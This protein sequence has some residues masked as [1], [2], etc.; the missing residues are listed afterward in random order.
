MTTS[1]PPD[2]P[3]GRRERMLA[4][5]RENGAATVSDLA[6]LFGVSPMTV[7]RDL[8]VIA[9]DGL[10]ERFRGGARVTGIAMLPDDQSERDVTLRRRENVTV[11]TLLGRYTAKLIGPGEIVALDDSTTVG[12]VGRYL[13]DRRPGGLITHSLSLIVELGRSMPTGSVICLGGR[14]VAA[15]DSF[16][17]PSTVSQMELLSADVSVVSTTSVRSGRLYHPD[18]DAALTKTGCIALGQR[19]IL[20]V[21][22]S[23]FNALGVHHVASLDEFDD[24]VVDDNLR[25]VDR[26]LLESCRANIHCIDTPIPS[27]ARPR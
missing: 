11:K 14:F 23:K 17:G 5:L 19:R 25:D 10:I 6:E 20:V 1:V 13:V 27:P 15:T 16:L 18:E 9:D 22:S 7:H 12:A 2:T 24:I 8:D 21:D 4:H 3:L 26:E